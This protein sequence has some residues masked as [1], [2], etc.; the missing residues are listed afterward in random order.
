MS[1]TFTSHIQD[2]PHCI[3]KPL[4]YRVTDL[5]K[6]YNTIPLLELHQF[7]LLGLVYKYYYRNDRLPSAVGNIFS[8]NKDIHH[9][10]TRCSDLLHL[11]RVNTSHGT[12]FKATHWTT[13]FLDPLLIEGA[14]PFVLVLA[15][16]CAMPV[17]GLQIFQKFS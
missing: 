3:N 9:Y 11:S 12:K 7:Q 14:P 2:S 17:H 8:V 15:L 6:N 13:S 5:Y 10:Q 16:H 1:L 4:R